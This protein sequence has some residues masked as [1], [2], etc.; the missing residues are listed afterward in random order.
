MASR[1]RN[2]GALLFSSCY[3]TPTLSLFSSPDHWETREG[4]GFAASVVDWGAVLY[5]AGAVPVE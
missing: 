4:L 3:V 1:L 2:G 5:A